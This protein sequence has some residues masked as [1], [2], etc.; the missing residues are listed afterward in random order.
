MK[1][2]AT[3]IAVLLT[4]WMLPSM[5][6]EKDP[7]EQ[8]TT[9]IGRFQIGLRLGI[10]TSITGRVFTDDHTAIEGLISMPIFDTRVG[11]TGLYEK[12][13]RLGNPG[14]G[15]FYGVGAHAEDYTVEFVKNAHA[16][17]GLIFGVDGILGV[18][19]IF[20]NSPINLS[21]D[22]KPAIDV[23]PLFG[24]PLPLLEFG[25]SIRYIF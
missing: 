21:L 16:Y 2:Y 1:K 3:L 7:S 4:L 19:Y 15:F 18:D 5:A 17:G 14:L 13:G 22:W 8:T 10:A 23:V 25:A 24:N 20:P 11:V 6:Q 12:F 9:T